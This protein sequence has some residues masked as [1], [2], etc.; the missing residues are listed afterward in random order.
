MIVSL[1]VNLRHA[2]DVPAAM[3]ATRRHHVAPSGRIWM[4]RPMR[5]GMRLARALALGPGSRFLRLLL[6]LRGRSTRIVWRL[7]WQTELG[8]E[9]HDTRRQHLDLPRQC[10]NRFRLRQNQADQCF[11]VERFNRFTIHPQLESA[12]PS[13]VK[14][15][16]PR[17]ETKGGEQLPFPPWGLSVGP[18]LSL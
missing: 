2:G 6:S 4:Q 10:G 11:L 1:A 16:P 17:P 13:L 7:R 8:F 18:Q 14:N 9:L 3:L 5:A 12:W 15:R